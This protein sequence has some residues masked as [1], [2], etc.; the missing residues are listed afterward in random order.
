MLVSAYAALDPQRPALTFGDV[1]MDRRDL[2]AAANRR[3]RQLLEL[4]VGADD[5]VVVALANGF[6]FYETVLAAWK[7]GATPAHVSYRLTETEFSE[8]LQ[9]AKPRLI[10]GGPAPRAES[11]LAYL[12]AGAAPDAALSGDALAARTAKVWKIST[13]GGSTGRPKLVIDPNPAVWGEEKSALRRDPGS[14]IINPGPLYH[15]APFGQMIPGLCQGCHVIEMGRFD[16]EHWLALVERHRA[17][18]VYLVPT[19]M[20]RIARLPTVVR[21][22][23]DV[24]SLKTLVHMA[25]PCPDWVKAFWIDFIGPDAIWEVY[26]GTERFGSTLIGGREWLEHRGSVGRPRPGIE[27]AILGEDRQA[28]PLGEVGEI[29]FRRDGGPEST[30]RYVGAQARGHGD[31]RSFG[32]LGRMD[33]DGYLYITDRRTDM[34]VCGGANLYPAEIEGAIDLIPG[35]VA[36]VVV[37]LPDEDLGQTAHAIVQIEPSRIDDLT[38]DHILGALAD[39]LSITKRPRSLEF[40]TRPLRDEAG[41]IRRSSWRDECVSRRAALTAGRG[42]V[43][44]DL[45]EVAN[46]GTVAHRP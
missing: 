25:A 38:I 9:L 41:K 15:S 26:G 42:T 33:A 1:T 13:S 46:A 12:P 24:S 17:D 32:D 16:A 2:E 39:R 21:Q 35:V 18:W 44:A 10:V 3:A 11:T 4:G 28:L 37:G 22:R 23:Y 45:S 36:S 8:I 27:A 43:Q 40:T 7:L 30:F 34:I 19:M 5:T 6:E 14:T 20:A 29:Y 31:W